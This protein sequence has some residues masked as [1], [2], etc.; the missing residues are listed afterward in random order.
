VGEIRISDTLWGDMATAFITL[1]TL[2]T[3]VKQRPGPAAPKALT[4]SSSRG[5]VSSSASI[6]FTLPS[7]ACVSLKIFDLRGREVATLVNNELLPA[8]SYT[9]RWNTGTTPSGLYFCRM[10]AGVSTLTRK[11]WR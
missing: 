2:T 3:P 7:D 6:S 9:R 11:V 1:D 5:P 8:G 4:L 10:R